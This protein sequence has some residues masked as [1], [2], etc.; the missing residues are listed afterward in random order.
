M[1]APILF[2]GHACHDKTPTGFKLGG[3]VSYAAA[4]ANAIG[5]QTVVLTSIGP[6]FLFEDNFTDAGV[7]LQIVPAKQTTVF[8]NRYRDA[9]RQQY[10]LQR[11]EKISKSNIPEELQPAIIFLCPIA[12]EINLNIISAYPDI[13]HA[14]TIQGFL[15]SWDEQ[16]KVSAT[17]MQWDR[18]SGLDLAIFSIDD[19]EGNPVWIEEITSRIPICVLTKGAAGAQLY[20]QGHVRSFPSWS[21]EEVDP[22]GAGDVFATAFLCH[23]KNTANLTL[24]MAY[25]HA[26]ASMVVEV[27]GVRND[28]EELP[29]RYHK[30]CEKHI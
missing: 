13:L 23:Y 26:A 1:K 7:Q 9:I 4:F 18:L 14:C 12:D 11:A 2:V 20:E 29:S 5:E 21:V 8:D 22:T 3:T 10:I 27:D 30:Y 16:G 28:W 6:D 24:S 15:R 19:V 17:A 25:A